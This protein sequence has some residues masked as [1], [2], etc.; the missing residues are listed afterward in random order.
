MSTAYLLDLPPKRGLSAFVG[1]LDQAG[2]DGVRIGQASLQSIRYLSGRSKT[3]GHDLEARWYQSLRDGDPDYS[4][5]DD[6]DYLIEAWACWHVYSRKYL[7]TVS[8]PKSLPPFGIAADLDPDFVVDLGNGFG[9]TTA[10]LAGI[11]PNAQVAGT[12]VAGSIQYEISEKVGASYG[13]DMYSGHTPPSDLVVAFEYFE[14]FQEPIA[15]LRQIIRASG[16]TAIWFA[17]TFTM[18][19]PGHFHQYKVD[20]EEVPGHLVSRLFSRELTNAGFSKVETN[21]W[22]G[23]PAYWKR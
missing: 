12:Q 4:I 14:H 10:A 23:R 7:R 18:M 2:V 21:A 1:L 16:A 17:N 15:H 8:N 11:Y 5:Y 9:F 19:S 22:N 3:P 20:G 13:F 6:E